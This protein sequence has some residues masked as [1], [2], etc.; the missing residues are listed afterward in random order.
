M[1]L[2]NRTEAR[3]LAWRFMLN[4]E[5]PVWC[6]PVDILLTANVILLSDEVGMCKASQGKLSAMLNIDD[7]TMR[8]S[9]DRLTDHSWITEESR[10]TTGQSNRMYPQYHNIP[11]G[12]FKT[13][14]V[15]KDANTLAGA[16]YEIV[17]ALPKVKTANGRMRKAVYQHQGWAQHWAYVMQ[18]WIDDGWTPEQ[19]RA[20]VDYAFTHKEW[21]LAK[22]GP[23]YL[24]NDGIFDKLAAKAGILKNTTK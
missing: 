3:E 15:C 1:K 17:R 13:V 8:R 16:Y 7:K 20:V 21:E 23:Q 4:P 2:P 19:I 22:R 18:C 5:K 11:F 10:K 6:L 24:R 9:L 14:N 12:V